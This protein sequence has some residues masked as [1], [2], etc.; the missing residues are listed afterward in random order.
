MEEVRYIVARNLS[1]LITFLLNGE[2]VFGYGKLHSFKYDN[3]SCGD[4]VF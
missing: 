4:T 1:L 3:F 2:E